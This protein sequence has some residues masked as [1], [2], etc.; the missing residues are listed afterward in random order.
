MINTEITTKA[1]AVTITITY[2]EGNNKTI[3]TSIRA[4]MVQAA[5]NPDKIVRSSLVCSLKRLFYKKFT[6]N[7]KQV[8]PKNMAKVR[9]AAIITSSVRW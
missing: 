8:K 3:R 5:M 6:M 1:I 9:V 7:A 4:I 2:R